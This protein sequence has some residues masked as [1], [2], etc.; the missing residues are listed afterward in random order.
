MGAGP[1]CPSS[2]QLGPWDPVGAV[3]YVPEA[4]L[5]TPS[6][7]KRSLGRAIGA[8]GRPTGAGE[9]QGGGGAQLPRVRA[10]E[11]ATPLP[12]CPSPARPAPG[13]VCRLAQPQPAVEEASVQWRL[14]SGSPGTGVKVF[15]AATH[16]GQSN[17]GKSVP[18]THWYVTKQAL[19]SRLPM[20]SSSPQICPRLTPPME[21]GGDH[22][23][24]MASRL[25]T[26][27]T[28]QPRFH[29]Q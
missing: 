24:E 17:G 22:L 20:P 8:E 12:G 21:G 29:I 14:K 23:P 15:I 18:A 7:L 13:C 27:P 16:R 25:P 9:Q 6:S 19:R 4:P 28:L 10:P 5:S 1:T 26:Q 2:D 11:P 3:G